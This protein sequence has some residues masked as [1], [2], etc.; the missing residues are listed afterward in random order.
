MFERVKCRG[1]CRRRRGVELQHIALHLKDAARRKKSGRLTFQR[2]PVKKFLF[3][4]NGTLTCA[5]SNQSEE[6]I[7][8]ILHRLGKITDR[9]LAKIDSFIEPK[10]HIGE[11][12]INNGLVTKNHLLEG[13]EFQMREI[14]LN[15]FPYFDGKFFFDEVTFIEGD[16]RGHTLEVF[17]LIADGIRRMDESPELVS[18][19]SEREFSA[20]DSADQ[21]DLLLYQEVE[22][23]NN[24]KLKPEGFTAKSDV[25][26]SMY[27]KRLF[28]L[29]A[30]GLIE[31][32]SPDRESDSAPDSEPSLES[33]PESSPLRK[34]LQLASKLDRM[35]YFQM[36]DVTRDVSAPEAK[37]AYLSKAKEFHPDLF[38]RHLPPGVKE[39]IQVVFDRINK[40]YRVLRD[41]DRKRSYENDL[42]KTVEE[43]H[44]KAMET[45]EQYFQKALRVFEEGRFKES[46]S[47]FSQSV[48]IAPSKA[49]YV[50][51][52]ALAQAK[53][54]IYRKQAEEGFMKAIQLEPWNPDYY[55]TLAQMYWE[56]GLNIK[57]EKLFRRALAAD[58]GCLR[59]EQ[60]IGVIEKQRKKEGRGK[61][62]GRRKL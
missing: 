3:L 11:M 54:P 14:V 59:A 48:K 40:A 5:V 24:V 58:P 7:G 27:W 49:S 29:F 31:P 50:Y 18:F 13:L 22:L 34:V 55:V 16:D 6:R 38:D 62:S 61:R 45:A 23:L 1:I 41:L 53:I 46:V 32:V 37:E 30:L 26:D 35:D 51:Y 28:L 25:K 43:V 36:L 2:S 10:K 60:A 4:K 44:R 56:E 9:T 20:S 12:L 47:L 17:P 42:D 33:Y 19:F 15:I 8:K 39:K 57:A 21:L 52:L